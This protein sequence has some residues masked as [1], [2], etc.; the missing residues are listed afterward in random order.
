MENSFFKNMY[1]VLNDNGY[2][3]LVFREGEGVKPTTV[4][5]NEVYA[6]NF[7]YHTKD[8]LEKYISKYFD[9]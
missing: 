4:Y 1:D 5:N 6:R 2:L 3:L 9:F 7:V 8:G